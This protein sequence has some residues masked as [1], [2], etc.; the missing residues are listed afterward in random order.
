MFRLKLTKW[1][2]V[3]I[4]ILFLLS[5]V[6]FFVVGTQLCLANRSGESK[7][8]SVL[9]QEALYAEEIEG[10]INAAIKIYQQIIDD[11]SAQ[12]NY[13]AQ[14]LYRQGLCYTKI[15]NEKQAQENFKRIVTD[16]SDQTSIVAKVKPLLEDMGNA[17][18]AALM[19]PETLYYMEIGSPGKQIETILNML[20]GSPLEN[21]W[22]LI[23]GNIPE[24]SNDQMG[25]IVSGL[26]N[27]NMMAELKKIRGMGIGI[28]GIPQNDVPPGVIVLFPGKSDALKGLLQMVLTMAGKPIDSIEGM[29]CVEFNAG[30][31]AAYDDSTVIIVTPPAYKAGQLEWSVKQYKGITNEPT[32][33][34]SNKSF[35]QVS[36]QA[37]QSNALTIWADA[38]KIYSKLMEIL[39]PDA[40]PPQMLMINGIVDF[41]NIKDLIAF[42]TL[43]ET[44][45]AV[46]VNISLNEGHNC[47]AYNMIRTPNLNKEVF[48]AIPPEAVGLLSFAL[49]DAESV[50]AASVGQQL[51]SITGL[52]FG[53][54]IF[55][56]IEQVTLFLT[57]PEN[58]SMQ[59]NQWNS[60]TTNL[61]LVITSGN[62]QQTRQIINQ[63]LTIAGLVPNS[64]GNSQSEQA[65]GKYFIE[66]NNGMQLH[67]YQDQS[68][69]ITLISMSP[70]V[71]DESVNSLQSKKSALTTGPLQK[72][73]SSMSPNTSKI[74][75]LNLGSIISQAN[76]SVGSEEETAN[77]RTLL[78]Q[79][80]EGFKET[81]FQ[82]RTNESLNDLNIRASINDLPPVGTILTPMMQIGQIMSQI[83]QP[84]GSWGNV[85]SPP[86][87]VAHTDKA[88]VIDGNAENI[89]SQLQSTSLNNKIYS[90]IS[91]DK[92]LSADYRAMWDKDNLY[93][94]VNVI[95]DSM[96]NDSDEHYQ[97]DSIE[98]FID[99]KQVD[100]MIMIINSTLD[101][102]KRIPL[103]EFITEVISRMILN[104]N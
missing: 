94:F 82:L 76:I 68:N 38:N 85:N 72:S 14:A 87:V 23:N 12:D 53:R 28:T 18:P 61:G 66:L 31:G 7:T 10:D 57:P 20:K 49:S 50:Q 98:I 89:W 48:K 24:A 11:D 43:E 35:A 21:P 84:S 36:K 93:V 58:M 47:I 3:S 104:T 97:D 91:S 5:I 44:G 8:A 27:P 2:G 42:L 88:P 13:L 77:L 65:S 22:A 1:P 92:D 32:L 54:E 73:L 33:A 60:A 101:G 37:R 59:D 80:A 75:L 74:L 17:D 83:H 15:Q 46:E 64:T 9:L 29:K 70:K 86:V 79:I 51:Q 69:K 96:Q 4:T 16:F 41:K 19:P 99:A 56:N 81:T 71:I 26:L 95:D 63:I 40:I 55:A 25:N 52:D 34:S 45:I 6:L 30:G 39:P 67:C 103:Q 78:A 90:A 100:M 62:P 102:K